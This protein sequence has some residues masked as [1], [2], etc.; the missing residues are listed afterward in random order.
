MADD[1]ED[2]DDV[3]DRECCELAADAAAVAVQCRAV[4]SLAQ[5]ALDCGLSRDEAVGF[6]WWGRLFGIQDT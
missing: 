6:R 2:E 4:E 1:G 5:R 3:E